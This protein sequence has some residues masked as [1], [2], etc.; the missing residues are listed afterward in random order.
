MSSLTNLLLSSA[1]G[2]G[3]GPLSGL[4]MIRDAR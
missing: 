4:L 1:I 2:S 3:H